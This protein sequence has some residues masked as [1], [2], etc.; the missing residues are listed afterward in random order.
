MTGSFI[1]ASSKREIRQITAEKIK[2]AE[3]PHRFIRNR[4][5]AGAPAV[6]NAMEVPK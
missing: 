5:R 6:A 1:A 2:R 4:P 3:K